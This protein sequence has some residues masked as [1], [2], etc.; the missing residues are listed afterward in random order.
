M[1]GKTDQAKVD[2]EALLAKLNKTSHD[3]EAHSEGRKKAAGQWVSHWIAISQLDLSA[4]NTVEDVEN[5]LIDSWI[6]KEIEKDS[7][8]QSL[9]NRK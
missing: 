6:N 8:V 5:A 3:E 4:C 2:A 9:I 1:P 7:L